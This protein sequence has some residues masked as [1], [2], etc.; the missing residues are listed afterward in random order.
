VISQQ[1]YWGPDFTRPGHKPPSAT[2]RKTARAWLQTS[3][4]APQPVTSPENTPQD[5]IPWQLII[6]AADILKLTG[7]KTRQSIAH[8]IDKR[9]FPAP[10]WTL[11][12]GQRLWDCRP[13]QEWIEEHLS[14]S[15]NRT[16][17]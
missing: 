14:T 17:P 5:V 13:V 15:R 8:A 16:E 11:T 10:A 12:G 6:N 3:D 2:E 9:G 1:D 4:A 7:W